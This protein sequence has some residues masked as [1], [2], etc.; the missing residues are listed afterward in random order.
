VSLP[1]NNILTF[2]IESFRNINDV[3]VLCDEIPLSA[4]LKY[5]GL[6]PVRGI[7]AHGGS[8]R[9]L[10]SDGC[11]YRFIHVGNC[12]D[13]L[14]RRI[15]PK[16]LCLCIGPCLQHKIF[17]AYDVEDPSGSQSRDNVEGS[18]DP[19][20]GHLLRFFF[21]CIKIDHLPFLMNCVA[22]GR[23]DCICAFLVFSTFD[24]EA[25]VIIGVFKVIAFIEEKLPPGGA[26][27][28]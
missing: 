16:L 5:L 20:A 11:C 13:G 1:K 8:V 12:F 14:G 27:I 18:I 3:P 4:V 10:I 2:V 15:I 26:G 9:L 22:F 19:E 24:V 7:N 23:Y 6:L 21:Y 28:P 25:F 17:A